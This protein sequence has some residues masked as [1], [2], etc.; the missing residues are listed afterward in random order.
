M[1]FYRSSRRTLLGGIC[2]GISERFG[3]RLFVVRFLLFFLILFTGIFPGL[4]IYF[5]LCM[6]I[7]KQ[8]DAYQPRV[9]SRS[10]NTIN[11]SNMGHAPSLKIKE[12][13]NQIT[14]ISN[15]ILSKHNS[16]KVVGRMIDEFKEK[17]IDFKN[18]SPKLEKQYNECLT[19]LQTNKLEDIARSIEENKIRMSSSST[20]AKSN[21]QNIIE[22]KELRLKLVRE[23][24]EYTEIIESK[25]QLILETIQ[26]IEVS[27]LH[28][29]LRSQIEDENYS[30][31][32][33]QISVLSESITEVSDI[34]KKT[35]LRL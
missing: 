17:I 12:I 2:A 34:F 7:P 6:F 25:L 26:N 15:N 20:D 22:Q 11:K 3:V 33:Q 19:F 31:I 27:V 28:A 35:K 10:S 30:D 9:E 29:E 23:I 24:K 18:Y 21:Y 1:F 13:A 16:N 4:F 5:L 14:K 8:N 32:Q